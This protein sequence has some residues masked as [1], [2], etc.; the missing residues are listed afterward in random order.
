MSTRQ[1]RWAQGVH[2][3]L[4]QYASESAGSAE[5]QKFASK[6]RSLARRLPSLLQ[7][8]GLIQ[9]LIFT[10]TREGAKRG[11]VEVGKQLVIDLAARYGD[12]SAEAL[13]KRIQGA[14]L[15][16]Y[17]RLS[18]ELIALARKALAIHES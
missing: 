18:E 2:S 1:Q 12:E 14:D 4:S 7:Q 3:Q 6:Y 15:R 5:G 11:G 17:L 8:S 10:Q 13:I 16:E 9:G